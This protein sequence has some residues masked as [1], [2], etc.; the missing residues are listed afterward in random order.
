MRS[1]S[2]W[3]YCRT[4]TRRQSGRRLSRRANRR[5]LNCHRAPIR[6]HVTKTNRLTQSRNGL[7]FQPPITHS[8]AYCTVR[9]VVQLIRC[10]AFP[11]RSRTALHPSHIVCA[12]GTRARELPNPRS[13]LVVSRGAIRDARKDPDRSRGYRLTHPNVG[14][15]VFLQVRILSPAAH[16]AVLCSP[17]WSLDSL[18]AF[19]MAAG[20]AVCS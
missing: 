19:L 16:G 5:T 2:R 6:G 15:D 9:S 3:R 18:L 8:H 20:T 1:R 10:P 11:V 17:L 13:K 12:G 14:A 7:G 4:T